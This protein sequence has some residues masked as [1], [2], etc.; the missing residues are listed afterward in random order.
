LDEDSLNA[1]IGLGLHELDLLWY[2]SA[3]ATRLTTISPRSTV[4]RIRDALSTCGSAG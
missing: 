4:P 1:A 2:E 3:V